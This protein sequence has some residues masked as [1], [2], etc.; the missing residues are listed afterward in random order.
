MLTP[1]V[2]GELGPEDATLTQQLQKFMLE[3]A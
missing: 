3:S 1:E 2:V